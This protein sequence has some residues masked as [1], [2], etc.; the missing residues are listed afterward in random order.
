MLRIILQNV[1]YLLKGERFSFAFFIFQY[2]AKIRI[3]TDD[4]G[5]KRIYYNSIIAIVGFA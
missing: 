3:Q 5:R 2:K 1:S 4:L